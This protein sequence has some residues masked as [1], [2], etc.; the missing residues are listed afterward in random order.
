MYVGL[1]DELPPP[2]T[3]HTLRNANA[4]DEGEGSRRKMKINV[5]KLLDNIAIAKRWRS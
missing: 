2:H 3:V 1:A 4:R 5:Y